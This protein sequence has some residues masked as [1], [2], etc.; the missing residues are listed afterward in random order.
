MWAKHVSTYQVVDVSRDRLRV[1]AVVGHVGERAIPAD[2]RVGDVPVLLTSIDTSLPGWSGP[3]GVHGA[4]VVAH[5][6]RLGDGESPEP[7]ASESR[8]ALLEPAP[9]CR[10]AVAVGD[11]V[12][13]VRRSIE[14]LQ[15]G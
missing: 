11:A 2:V 1:R 13:E 7:G 14:A 3:G 6:L 12:A 5:R 4:S 8:A 15:H 10:L 9:G